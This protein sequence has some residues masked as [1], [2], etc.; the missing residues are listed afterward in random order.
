MNTYIAFYKN[1]QIEVTALT[2]YAAQQVAAKQFKARKSY[3][4]TVVIVE[5][6]GEVVT[7]STASI[8]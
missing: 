2:S 3:E 6:D 1:R 8:G 5:S 4:V 7:H